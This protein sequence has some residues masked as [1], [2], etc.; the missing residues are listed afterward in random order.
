MDKYI[1]ELEAKVFYAADLIKKWCYCRKGVTSDLIDTQFEDNEV[2]GFV[3][4]EARTVYNKLF[5]IFC[6]KDPDYVMKI[7]AS[8]MT[9]YKL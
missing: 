2:S 1:T 3:M 6:I 4:I 9:L 7:M 5:K 8:W